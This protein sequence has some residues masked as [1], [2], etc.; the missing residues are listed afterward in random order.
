LHYPAQRPARRH[1]ILEVLGSRIEA[2]QLLEQPVGGS[3]LKIAA[4]P[5]SSRAIILLLSSRRWSSAR[6]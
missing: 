2:E 3:Q 1:P 5:A 6:A 4:R